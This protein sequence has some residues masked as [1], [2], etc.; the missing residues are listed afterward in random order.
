MW[1]IDPKAKSCKLKK[2][3][4]KSR[5]K[6]RSKNSANYN[7][8]LNI[9]YYQKLYDCLNIPVASFGK[10]A[11]EISSDYKT[12]VRFTKKALIIFQYSMEKYLL[13]ILKNALLLT[14]NANR[15]RI[16]PKDIN[17]AIKKI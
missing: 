4:R 9:K 7:A 3:K 5:S 6:S 12:D 17:L 11:R 2:S 15:T 13:E 10:L 14:V 1:S 8:L 16:E